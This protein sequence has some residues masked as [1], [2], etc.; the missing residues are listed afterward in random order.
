MAVNFPLLFIFP[1]PFQFFS[2]SIFFQLNC[3]SGSHTGHLPSASKGNK[4]PLLSFPPTGCVEKAVMVSLPL[5]SI[6]PL[7][8]PFFLTAAFSNQIAP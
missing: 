6:F 7:T 5:V 1:P 3:Y 2:H 4:G 8:I